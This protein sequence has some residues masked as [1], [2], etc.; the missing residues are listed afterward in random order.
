MLDRLNQQTE[1]LRSIL[2]AAADM[3]DAALA[4]VG[5]QPARALEPCPA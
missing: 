3:I 5:E 1:A 2:P 4:E